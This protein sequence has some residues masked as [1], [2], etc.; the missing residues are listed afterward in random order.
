MKQL[1]TNW[2][3]WET[4]KRPDDLVYLYNICYINISR[5][6]EEN[7]PTFKH[8]SD[9]WQLTLPTTVYHRKVPLLGP[10]K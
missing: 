4:K 5:K 3:L 9:S 7:V 2:E 10:S 8:V 1:R 6:G